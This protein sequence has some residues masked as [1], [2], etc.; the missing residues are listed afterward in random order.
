MVGVEVGIVGLGVIV[1]GGEFV[2]F[3]Y[4]LRL[5]FVHVGKIIEDVTFGDFS[6]ENGEHLISGVAI[7][8]IA[9]FGLDCFFSFDVIE[10][11]KMFIVDV[12]DVDPFE[13]E[14]SFEFEGVIFPPEGKGLLVIS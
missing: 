5:P 11:V 10:I 2:H 9:V 4:V 14:I 6:I 1:V 12:F 7:E 13:F 3:T 8:C